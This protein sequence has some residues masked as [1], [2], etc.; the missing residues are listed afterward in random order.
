MAD[1]EQPGARRTA[2][3]NRVRPPDQNQEGRLEGILGIVLVSKNGPADA[4]H[5]CAMSLHQE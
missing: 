2:P 5:H 4:Q 3:V 1:T